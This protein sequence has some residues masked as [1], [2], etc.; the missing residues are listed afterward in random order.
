MLKASL[1]NK[2]LSSWAR[3]TVGLGF[4]NHTTKHFVTVNAMGLAQ[5]ILNFLKIANSLTIGVWWKRGQFQMR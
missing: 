5:S 1:Y 2:I 3:Q 4:K